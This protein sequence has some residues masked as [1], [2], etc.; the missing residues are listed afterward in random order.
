MRRLLNIVTASS[1]LLLCVAAVV[2]WVRGYF[3]VD[4]P[5][6]ITGHDDA[7][8]LGRAGGFPGAGGSF[9]GAGGSFRG[10]NRPFP[11]AAVSLARKRYSME[12]RRRGVGPAR[13]VVSDRGR[14]APPGRIWGTAGTGGRRERFET[15]SGCR[16]T[17]APPA[18]D[19]AIIQPR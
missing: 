11:G 16:E 7:R 6:V 8:R 19:S 1:L 18:T 3:V 15:F 12:R 9:P 10:M 17:G 14:R 13:A 2:L 5:A 4:V